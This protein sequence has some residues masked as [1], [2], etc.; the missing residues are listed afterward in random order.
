MNKSFILI[1]ATTLACF[2]VSIEAEQIKDAT[3]ECRCAEEDIDYQLFYGCTM[4]FSVCEEFLTCTRPIDCK[5]KPHSTNY[6]VHGIMETLFNAV[7]PLTQLFASIASFAL[8]ILVFAM[9]MIGASFIVVIVPLITVVKIVCPIVDYL[10]SPS[11]WKM[12]DRTSEQLVRMSDV[13]QKF[14]QQIEK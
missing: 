2:V 9:E 7:I 4:G 1:I 14:K 3:F 6:G 8:G 13:V 11:I 12:F 5:L 10:N